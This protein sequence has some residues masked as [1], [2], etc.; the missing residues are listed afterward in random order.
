MKKP[1]SKGAAAAVWFKKTS[2]IPGTGATVSKLGFFF[3][4]E[5]F[6]IYY[7]LSGGRVVV[8]ETPLLMQNLSLLQQELLHGH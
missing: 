8:V 6:A 2:N 7:T 1:R 5:L 4:H 3:W